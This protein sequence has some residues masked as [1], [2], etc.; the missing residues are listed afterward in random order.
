MHLITLVLA[1]AQIAAVNGGAACVNGCLYSGAA[2]ETRVVAPRVTGARI[3]VDGQIS[4]PEWDRA[5]VLSEFSQYHPVEGSSPTQETDVLVFLTDEAVYLGIRAHDT[6]PERIRASLTERDNVETDDFVRI[7]LDTFNDQRQAYAFTVNPLGVQADGIWLE[8]GGGGGG[9][10]TDPIS[11]DID[12]LWDSSGHIRSWGYEVEV[13]I[14]FKSLRFP[15]RSEQD[16]G[17]QVL[18]VIQREGYRDSWAPITASSANRLAQSGKLLSLQGLDPGLFLELNP[19]VTGSRSGIY[20]ITTNELTHADPSVEAGVNATYGLTSNLILDATVNPDFS[21]VEADAGQIAVNERFALFFSE[22]RQFFLQGS[23]IFELPRRLIYTRSFVNPIVGGKIMGKVGGVNIGYL[24]AVDQAGIVDDGAVVNLLRGRSD[25]GASSTVGVVYT[26][27]TASQS[28][29]NRVLGVDGHLQLGQRYIV[30]LLGAGSRTATESA[31]SPRTGRLLQAGLERVDRNFMFNVDFADMTPAFE[32]RSG[33]L[34]RT[35]E[36]STSGEI[37]YRWY[38][39][40]ENRVERV[41]PYISF[42]TYWEHEDFWGGEPVKEWATTQGLAIGMRGNWGFTFTHN[43]TGFEFAAADYDGL[44]VSDEDGQLHPFVADQTDFQWLNGGSARLRLDSWERIRGTFSVTWLE[45]PLFQRS[46]RVPIEIADS[47]AFDGQFALYPTRALRS[48]I[49]I[50]H[51]TMSR[52][53]SGGHY[54]SATIPRLRAQ[55]HFTRSLFLRTIL[56]YDSESREAL[57]DP[58]TG[59]ILSSCTDEC[60]MEAGAERHEIYGELLLSY[61]P[62]PGS[63]VYVG[64]SRQMEEPIAFGF[65]RLTPQQDGLFVKASYR[66]RF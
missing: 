35:G 13:R 22:Q 53:G 45:T 17:I 25:L 6:Q 7:V 52:P 1:I 61:E 34:D 29:Y 46:L 44:F 9:R 62:S 14:P 8:T 47:W 2:G 49:G 32:A 24:G 31:S 12:F 42:N 55:Y 18:R 20:D 66:F 23:E 56:E 65:S 43:L 57:R 21:Q 5:A 19:V 4:E 48:E 59:R 30:T 50:R 37:R 27:R 11:A 28:E 36:T 3:A 26:D 60:V 51:R 39:T 33:F 40:L 58:L 54:S 10:A 64:S 38:G 41:S 63:V 15:N 16:W